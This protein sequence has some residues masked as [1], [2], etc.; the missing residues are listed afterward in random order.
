MRF[1]VVEDEPQARKG[2]AGLLA[3]H[4]SQDSVEVAM[5]GREALE[6]IRKRVP[7][8]IIT[9]IR[10]PEMDGLELIETVQATPNAIRWIVLSAFADFEYAR[11]AVHLGVLEY[12]VKPVSAA[13]LL[14][15]I[16]AIQRKGPTLAEKTAALLEAETAQG[17]DAEAVFERLFPTPG[18]T[19]Q[20][21]AARIPVGA[22]GLRT[23]RRLDNLVADLGVR[24]RT[25]F[26]GTDPRN[27]WIF[28][29]SPADLSFDQTLAAALTKEF[30][31][32][33]PLG[34][35][36]A[37]LSV[38][39]PTDLTTVGSR[40]PSLW[41]WS[42]VRPETALLTEREI[43]SQRTVE[44]KACP[45]LLETRALAALRHADPVALKGV[46]ENFLDL[47]KSG[48]HSPAD[49]R[50]AAVGLVLSL[51]NLLK[52][53]DLH[54]YDEA[55]DL[56]LLERLETATTF[57]EFAVTLLGLCP[58]AESG[59][60]PMEPGGG[61]QVRKAVELIN[62][63][64]AE[65]LSLEEVARKVGLSPEYLSDLIQERTG[66]RFSAY[67]ARVR[68]E[69]AKRLLVREDKK[70][71]EI[72]ALCGYPDAGYFSRIFRA[73]TGMTPKEFV[74]VR[75]R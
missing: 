26:R 51:L 69:E 2:L 36:T 17:A 47:V 48:N 15:V 21:A 45:V 52:E 72:A 57:P 37:L 55:A 71:R 29:P 42:V 39:S 54:R 13:E 6:K 4:N 64:F 53:L 34:L 9:D 46:L 32:L 23:L 35:V 18:V 43:G 75:P 10:M 70:V 33:L 20:V 31:D 62:T 30:Q 68:L 44:L 59:K 49:A 24:D 27:L 65:R 41:K 16:D 22:D 63:F 74:T 5:N 8:V 7:D 12:L 40:V 60:A 50:R 61:I 73:A 28:F 58:L 56:R 1:L 14:G 3:Q 25:A 11:R 38:D 19:G 67:L 66:L